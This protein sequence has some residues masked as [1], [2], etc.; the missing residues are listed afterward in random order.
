MTITAAADGS[1]LGNPGPAGWAWYVDENRWHAGGWPHGTNNQGELMAVLDLFRATAH[2]P[3]EPLRIL[4]DSQYVINCVTKWMP[5]W[6]RRGWKKADGKPVLNVELL[7]QIDSEL[8]GRV[9]T[10]EW[11]K[12]HA[13]HSLNEAADERARA[14]ATA[15][16]AGGTPVEGP[17]FPGG[18]AARATA[19][20]SGPVAEP[21]APGGKAARATAAASGP[22]AEP[23][24]PGGKAAARATAAASGPVAEPAAPGGKAAARATAAAAGGA[25]RGRSADSA[26]E[27][28]RAARPAAEQ[29]G[30]ERPS[31]E[32]VQEDLFGEL[33]EPGREAHVADPGGAASANGQAAMPGR[34]DLEA[35]V[36]LEQELLDPE[37][38]GDFGQL[39]YL[40]H[41]EYREIGQSGRLWDRDEIVDALVQEPE[42]NVVFELVEATPLAPDLIQVV[43]RTE[44]AEGS[45]LRSSLWQR[46]DDRWRIRFHQGTREA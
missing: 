36:E 12:G 28:T 45:C 32:A 13:G 17:G 34:S 19:A 25:A 39:A 6:K 31:T 2:V 21:A 16:Q 29:P 8:V 4:C 46:T 37:T 5:G 7:R 3:D 33:A 14:C 18:K 38:R 30:A 22:V 9:Y 40:L 15:Y 23:A 11:V 35:V 10:F 26:G 24:A 43:Y 41:P 42:L 27:A 1:A 44:S 20:A